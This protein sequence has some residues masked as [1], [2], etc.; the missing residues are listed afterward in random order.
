MGTPQANEL[1][2]SEIDRI[3]LR[4]PADLH[5]EIRR[6]AQANGRSVNSE[7]AARLRGAL[8]V[9]EPQPPYRPAG[10]QILESP[11]LDQRVRGLID[12]YVRDQVLPEL[13]RYIDAR[14]RTRP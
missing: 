14:L 2:P 7:I 9:E 6:A 13:Q 8:Q 1:D 11:I 3:T 4:I 5:E 10:E 12:R